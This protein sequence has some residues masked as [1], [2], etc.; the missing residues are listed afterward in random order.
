MLLQAILE[1]VTYYKVLKDGRWN[2]STRDD[3]TLE[4]FLKI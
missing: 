3:F 1:K 4:I 2:K